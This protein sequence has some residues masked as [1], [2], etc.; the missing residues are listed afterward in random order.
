MSADTTVVNVKV[1]YLRPQFKDLKEW[2]D[3]PDNVYIGRGGIVF[4]TI[5][6]K[7]QRYPPTSKW[8]NPFTVKKYGTAAI[9]MF[10]EYIRSVP[11]ID[12]IE[13]LRG[14]NLGCWCVDAE[15]PEIQCHG[16]ILVKILNERGHCR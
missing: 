8:C 11:Y 9:S 5:D 3:H 2:C 12:D 1:K 4:V 16:H 10:E 6:G 15:H 13:S 7:K 14:K